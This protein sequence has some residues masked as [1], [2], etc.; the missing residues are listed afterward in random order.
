[1]SKNPR[2]VVAMVLPRGTYEVMF[3]EEELRRLRDAAEVFGPFEKGDLSGLQVGL[4]EAA[5]AITGWGSPLFDEVFLKAAPKLKLIA[6]S[7]G[8]VKPVVSDAVFD[9]GIHVTTAA[10]AN[11]T[12]VAEFTIAMMQMMLKQVP[13]ISTAYK[14]GD[15]AAR[16]ERIREL[17]DITIGLISAS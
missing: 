7:A 4:S 9:R 3:K 6:H 13:W 12:V 5:A 16:N 8:S 2:P 10:A 17:R 14:A 1:M 11:A 15:N